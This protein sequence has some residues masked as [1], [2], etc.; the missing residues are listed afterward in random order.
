MFTAAELS[1]LVADTVPAD[2]THA[3]VLGPT[4]SFATA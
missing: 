4:G 3:V 2:R 1:K